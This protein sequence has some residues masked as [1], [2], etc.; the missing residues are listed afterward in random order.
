MNIFQIFHFLF[1]GLCVLAVCATSSPA[2][3]EKGYATSDSHIDLRKG[4]AT[5]FKIVQ[6]VKVGEELDILES[7]RSLGWDFVRIS[8]SG[9]EGWILH[10]YIEAEPPPKAQLETSKE[11]QRLAEEERDRLRGEVE[12]LQKQVGA[13]KK[14]TDELARVQKISRNVLEIDQQNGELSLKVRQME[15]EITRLTDDNR[16]LAQ[17]S[18]STFFLA[19]AAVLI[20]GFISGAV[21]ARRRRSS[22]FGSLE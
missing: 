2:W 12:T 4:P 17:E 15:K 8:K 20:V 13:E 3:A 19:G 21:I 22:P 14:L 7:D 6:M 18:D 1:L 10:R 9:R 11:G 5:S 16:L